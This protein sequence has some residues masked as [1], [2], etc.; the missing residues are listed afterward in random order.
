LP[1]CLVGFRKG[2]ARKC[3]RRLEVLYQNAKPKNRV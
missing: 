1:N 3:R 2:M